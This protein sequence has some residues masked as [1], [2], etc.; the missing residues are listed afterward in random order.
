MPHVT[1]FGLCEDIKQSQGPHF[2]VTNLIFLGATCHTVCPDLL[3]SLKHSWSNSP[4]KRNTSRPVF[5][6]HERSLAKSAWSASSARLNRDSFLPF[7]SCSLCLESAVDPV[8]CVHGDI[9]CRECALNNILAQKKEIK[10]LEKARENEEKDAAE[11]KA[12]QDEEAQARA[13]KEFELVQAGFDVKET[14]ERRAGEKRKAPLDED[15]VREQDDRTKA[16]KPNEDEKVGAS[17][18]DSLHSLD[19]LI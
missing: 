16:R 6:A 14:G 7:G 13:V 18:H 4:G 9:F 17:S 5:T 2:L 1:N 3:L 10:R 8:A 11:E 12:R 19:V 15:E